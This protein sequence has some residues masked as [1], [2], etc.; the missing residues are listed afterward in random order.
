MAILSYATAAASTASSYA[1]SAAS[2][3]VSRPDGTGSASSTFDK[4]NVPVAGSS[5]TSS[6][7][8]PAPPLSSAAG[9][10]SAKRLTRH[11]SSARRLPSYNPSR[12]RTS[13]TSRGSIGSASYAGGGG[14][15]PTSSSG[16]RPTSSDQTGGGGGGARGEA[17]DLVDA[18]NRTDEL[19]AILGV[20]RRAK[21]EEIRRGFL[22][23]SRICHPDKLPDYPPS[24]TAF[25]RLSYAYETLSKPSSRRIYDL[26]GMRSFETGA[27]G[28]SSAAEGMADKTLN[29]VLQSV[30]NEFLNGEFE[31][32]RVFVT[33][34]NEG[35][36]GLNLGEDAVDN[37]ES[38]F[39]RAREVL[40]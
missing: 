27:P 15:G 6:S 14:G 37:L 26:G 40:L 8:A 21:A 39:R 36:P 35:S 3:Y 33:A 34:L 25:Q 17:E 4:E 16:K 20:G 31:M 10:P 13:S 22:G 5:S 18:I 29:G 24:T 7:S 19:Y 11:N 30:I 28:P 9:S 32:I 38:A 1:F 23:R 2:A 12:N